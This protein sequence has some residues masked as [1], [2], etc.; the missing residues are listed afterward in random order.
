VGLLLLSIVR[1]GAETNVSS[2]DLQTINAVIM[3]VLIL[4]SVISKLLYVVDGLLDNKPCQ[5]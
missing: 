3:K 2:G 1:T 4:L 5:L